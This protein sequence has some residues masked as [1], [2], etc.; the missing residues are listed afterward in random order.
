MNEKIH[1]LVVIGGGINGVGIAADAAGR[2]L[3]VAL[4]EADDLAS[5]TSSWSSKLIHGGLRYL[6]YYQFRLVKESLAER[7]VLLK[8]APHLVTPLR[9]KMPHH[10]GLRPAWMISAG[11][12]LYDHLSKRVSLPGSKRIHFSA[13][14]CLQP[15]F[16]IG[17]EYSDCRVDD[18]RLVV[19]N[20]KLAEQKGALILTRCLVTGAERD[21]G[22]WL[23]S[24]T[25]AKGETSTLQAKTLVNAAGPWVSQVL[26]Q[27]PD[28]KSQHQ[29]RLVKGSHLVVPRIHDDPAAYIL[30]NNDGRIVFVIPYLDDYS[31]IGTTD[32]DYAGD[33]RTPEIDE[34]EI[35]YLIK[36][37]TDYFRCTL[38]RE[39][40]VWTY[41]GVRPLMQGE[42]EAHQSATKI[43]R[44]YQLELDVQA[45]QAPLL[46]V[47][48]GKLTTYR[49]LSESVLNKLRPYLPA[50]GDVWTASAILPG[51]EGIISPQAYA[52]ELA[53]HYPFLDR[54]QARRLA[55]TYGRQCEI[56]LAGAT[57]LNDLGTRY[58]V[59]FE[60]EVKYLI[61]EEW[62]KSCDDIIWRRTKVGI[63]LPK[64]D[65]QSLEKFVSAYCAK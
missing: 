38:T 1:D 31:L 3:S 14:S 25:T 42:H 6:E 57:S 65:A 43:T 23:I 27:I 37:T 40:I 41:S 24:V 9:F 47:Y 16:K 10:P 11:L 21:N 48:G 60:R 26:K 32:V 35:D 61:D 59:L 50:M 5:G 51:G 63:S 29:V 22:I 62:A 49:K 56:W 34:A 46:S 2:G 15:E 20:A 17:F 13:D 52:Q 8:M 28:G 33:P 30:Q 64:A 39:A 55:L 54:Q 18:A 36:V 44:D 53:E 7:E 19:M 58:G 12:F 45:G 4:L